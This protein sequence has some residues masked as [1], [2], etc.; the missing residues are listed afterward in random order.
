[1]MLMAD[2][3]MGTMMTAVDQHSP[4]ERKAPSAAGREPRAGGGG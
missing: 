3:F 4:P 1:M 2:Y